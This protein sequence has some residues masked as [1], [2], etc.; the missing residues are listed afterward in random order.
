MKMSLLKSTLLIV[1]LFAFCNGASIKTNKADECD[2][3]QIVID[4]IASYA[5]VT[6]QILD[7]FTKGPFKGETWKR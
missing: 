3:P 4:E 6:N 2:L 7:Y 5:T 1:A